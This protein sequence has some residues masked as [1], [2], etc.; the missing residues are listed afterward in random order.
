[1]ISVE[2]VIDVFRSLRLLV[3]GDVMLDRFIYG[4]VRR[5]S[6]E[7]P[8]PIIR[9]EAPQDRAGGAGN[10]AC[11]IA[12]LGARCDLVGVV[13]ADEAAESLCARLTASPA[14]TAHLIRDPQRRTTLKTR[15]V[16]TLHSTHLLRADYEDVHAI[17]PEIEDRVIAAA[18]ACLPTADAIVLSDYAKGVL[19]DRVL[20]AIISAA[21]ALDRPV[22]VD[23]K[24][25]VFARYAG[26]SVLTPNLGELAAAAGG[27][28]LHDDAS[29]ADAARRVMMETG[30]AAL[31][32]TRGEHGATIMT[33]KGEV[34]SFDPTAKRVVD[35]SGAG[36]TVAAAFSLA[37]AAGAGF[38]H[39][40]RL[41]N[42]AAG[43]AVAKPSTGDVTAQELRAVLLQR[44]RFDVAA[45]IMEN[46]AQAEAVARGWQQEGLVV[47]F[48]NGC[49]DLLHAG[50]IALLAGARA[51]CDRL[52]VGLNDDASVSRLKGPQRPIQQEAA[53]ATVLAAL[54][55]V[56]AVVVFQ[57]DT[58]LS[59][60]TRLAPDVLVK[61]ADYTLDWVVG[62]EVV[63]ARGGRVCLI[64]MV[65]ETSTTGLIASITHR[66]SSR[67]G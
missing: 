38:V 40:T 22:V 66:G 16:A 11:N 17:S 19:T 57:E 46:A 9:M 43:L 12:A 29:I 56:D 62:R 44:P 18:T 10:V 61:G 6:P 67:A 36:D 24:S 3:V 49:F 53:R 20:S 64:D 45:R 33:H 21:R 51:Q 55:M 59:L 4:D 35:V 32:V 52:I 8:V 7:A 58:P 25:A 42:T 13:G 63:E 5:I 31:L 15:Y 28:T 41:A 60:I 47:G 37:L 39:A 23:P 27:Q 54:Q 14:V 30:C 1:M 34:V 50:H 2:A 48:T 65:S 26:A